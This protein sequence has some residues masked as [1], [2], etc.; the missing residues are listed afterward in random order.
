MTAIIWE[1]RTLPDK[2]A[3]FEQAYGPA[4][5]WVGL[6]GKSKGYR[7]TELFIDPV[8]KGRY[9]TLDRWDSLSAYEEF[10]SEHQQEYSALDRRF[11]SCMA[12][13]L[14]IGSFVTATE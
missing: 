6:F 9:V 14:F 11:E 8:N 13:E 7:G 2:A 3:E 1:F 12:Q 10:K 4:G 5:D